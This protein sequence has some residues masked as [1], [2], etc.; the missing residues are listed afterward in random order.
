[1]WVDG[2]HFKVRL[3]QDNVCRLVMIGVRGDATKEL[4]ALSDGFRESD[5]SWADLLRDCKR[6]GMTAP[7]LAVG[8]GALGFW[9]AI[10]DVFPDT[11]EQR[12]WWHMIGARRAPEVGAP[13]R[14]E[15]PGR[16]RQRREQG[17]AV[18]A[19]HTFA[20][21]YGAKSPKA[22][23]KIGD[24][25]DVLTAF[26]DYPAEHWIHLRSTDESFKAMAALPAGPGAVRLG[27]GRGRPR[28]EEQGLGAG[29]P[30]A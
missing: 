28:S 18:K 6:R 19:A 14:E 22:V 5:E 29:S 2:I 10:R 9:K 26:Y 23:A 12:C 30:A 13:G 16:D 11:K 21:E 15:G 17:A 3:K 4:V 27:V 20:T 8:G 25:F 24:D 7:V 1:V